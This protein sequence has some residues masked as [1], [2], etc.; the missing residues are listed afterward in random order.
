[1]STTVGG[2]SRPT[3]R[4][5]HPLALRGGRAAAGLRAP[6][7]LL[8]AIPRAG[9]ACFL[10]AFVNGAIWGVLVL[11]FNVPDETTHFAYAQYL[12]ETGRPPPGGDRSPFSTQERV[13][14]DHLFT[15]RVIG[16]PKARGILTSHEERG[17]RSALAR[18]PIP[19]GEGGATSVTDQPPLYYAL[20]AIPYWLSPSHDIL[21]R[22]EFMRL[23]SALLAAGTVLAVFMFLRELLP[24]SPWAWTVGALVVAFQP[25][26]ALIAGGVQA[27][28]L[29]FLTSPL[30]FWMLMR[31]Y[32]RGLTMPRALALG[33]AIAAGLLTKLTFIGLLPGI[34]AALA[35]LGWRAARADGWRS[36]RMIAAT[37]A[38]AV[39]PA[40][41]Y[42][43]LNVTAWHR[44]SPWAGGVSD[45]TTN[46]L[47]N[48]VTITLGQT[49]EYIWQ[50]YLP[51][52]SFMHA[53]FGNY[54]LWNTWLNGSIGHL[55]WLD[56]TFPTWVYSAG[57]YLLYVL[58]ALAL[59]TLVRLRQRIPPVLPIFA[60]FGLMAAG[61]MAAIG[62]AGIRYRLANNGLPF[63]QARY[64]F[65]L[66]PLYAVFIVLA[67]RGLGPRSAGV[68]GSA[69]VAL[70]MIHGLFAETLT[71]SR[72][73]G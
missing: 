65:P 39:L 60:C 51:R 34:A 4:A 73:Y 68:L 58:V 15:F 23:F 21:A 13:A 25:T 1:V 19:V 35:L 69:L 2:S 44:G 54:P 6:L 24:A 7:A 62:Y 14:L 36:T 43:L 50:L 64:I 55:G 72:Y 48:G 37:V 29:L 3:Q 52:L 47:P 31:S 61:L 49:L 10:I 30:V 71:I 46:A 11:P 66:L 5:R 67:A 20:E 17:L 27:D 56:Y 26:F 32:R 41:L 70:A 16:D 42:A 40:A 33:A 59:A 28:N 53:Y 22:L 9:R 57:R 18:H 38:T 12:A 8:A 45:V 63:E